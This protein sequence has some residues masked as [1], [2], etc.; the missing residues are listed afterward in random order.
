MA[1]G[2]NLLYFIPF[3]WKVA[4]VLGIFVATLL[5]PIPGDEIISGATMLLVLMRVL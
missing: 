3:Y 4:I 2:L 1:R 5:T